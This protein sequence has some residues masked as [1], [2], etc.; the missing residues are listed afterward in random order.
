MIINYGSCAVSTSTTSK[1]LVLW[2]NSGSNIYFYSSSYWHFIIYQP[3]PTVAAIESVQGNSSDHK[4]YV[5]ENSLIT[6]T[7]ARLFRSYYDGLSGFVN[8]EQV[9]LPSQPNSLYYFRRLCIMSNG[10]MA[11]ASSKKVYISTD[12]GATWTDGASTN[13]AAY[14]AGGVSNMFALGEQLVVCGMNISSVEYI[15]VFLKTG[16][17]NG[18][19]T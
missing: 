1:I 19:Y 11:I 2:N 16:S 7:E 18:S 3:G 14:I 15:T 5:M 9:T 8:W 4:V 10:W 12:N 6:G 13:L 17:L